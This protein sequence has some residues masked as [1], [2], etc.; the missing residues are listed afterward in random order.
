MSPRRA[1]HRLAIGDLLWLCTGGLL[2]G[3]AY[4]FWTLNDQLSLRNATA[5]Q[6]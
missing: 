5:R 6:G 1:T 4:D 2:L 3:G